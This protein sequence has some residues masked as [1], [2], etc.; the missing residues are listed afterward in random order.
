MTTLNEASEAVLARFVSQWGSTTPYAFTNEEARDLDGGESA[1]AWV[2]VAEV[3]GGQE[4]LGKK[5]DRKYERVAEV[6]IQVFTPIGEGTQEGEQL[7]S[8]ARGIYE[9]ERFSGLYFNDG[10][11]TYVG[12]SEEKWDQNN[13]VIEFRFYETK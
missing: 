13:A 3:G 4:T 2:N 7:A 10:R 8:Q 1:W 6:R 9:G 11:V 5:G 12:P